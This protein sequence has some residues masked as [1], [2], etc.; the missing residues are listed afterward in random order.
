MCVYHVF[1]SFSLR[2]VYGILVWLCV[3]DPCVMVCAYVDLGGLF[4]DFTLAMVVVVIL[5]CTCFSSYSFVFNAQV[6]H[7]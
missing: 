3:Q 2:G 4:E 1:P 5:S 6:L 7:L